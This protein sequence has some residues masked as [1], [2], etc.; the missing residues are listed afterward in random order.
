MLKKLGFAMRK[1]LVVTT[2]MA[3]VATVTSC[4]SDDESATGSRTRNFSANLDCGQ[5]AVTAPVP[6]EPEEQ[7]PMPEEDPPM[8]DTVD[9]A[10][11][12]A[13]ASHALMLEA[14]EQA[15]RREE[16]ST[17][18]DREA[19][20]ALKIAKE[21]QYEQDWAAAYAA[22][23]LSRSALNDL[24]DAY[25]D[26]G[27][28]TAYHDDVVDHAIGIGGESGRNSSAEAERNACLARQDQMYADWEAQQAALELELQQN[29]L[30]LI[31]EQI[32]ALDESG[33][34]R[35]DQ[36]V[37]TENRVEA[38]RRAAAA[39]DKLEDF[40]PVEDAADEFAAALEAFREIQESGDRSGD[41]YKKAEDAKKAAAKRVLSALDNGPLKDRFDSR[42]IRGLNDSS[43][44]DE[45]FIEAFAKDLEEVKD[46]ADSS[47]DAAEAAEAEELANYWERRGKENAINELREKAEQIK[48]QADAA[49]QAYYERSQAADRADQNVIDTQ[50]A[51]AD[52][53]EQGNLDAIAEAEQAAADAQ[54]AAEAAAQAEADAAAAAQADADAAAGDDE[55][56][57]VTVS[58]D[59]VPASADD[60]TNVSV[61]PA[62]ILISNP[63][64]VEVEEVVDELVFNKNNVKDLLVG[65]GVAV[66]AVEVKTNSGD[67]QTLDQDA[68]NSLPLG[69][70]DEEV[71]I[72]VTSDDSEPVIVEKVVEIVRVESAAGITPEQ[73]AMLLPAASTTTSSSSNSGL[74]IIV[75]IVGLIALIAVVVVRKKKS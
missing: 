65:S 47:A 71:Q 61:P 24:D 27:E 6:D 45:K 5:E 49:E 28:A 57:G 54:A 75:V 25:S 66:G 29:D 48:E 43:R 44:L 12:A 73:L 4:G 40:S 7:A 22:D 37:L 50:T 59:A 21:T 69:T 34:T 32:N 53:I 13:N 11:Q 63:V 17:N 74:L 70:N 23:K 67:W 19:A 60:D 72:R 8:A 35:D 36:I 15:R 64:A 16:M 39:A 26:L 14:E 55:N 51:L 68:T 1:L 38:E 3:L 2:L 62:V 30:R 52:A 58:V 10:Q 9:E 33:V 56:T 20:E 31:N 18:Y 41:A 42:T 46:A